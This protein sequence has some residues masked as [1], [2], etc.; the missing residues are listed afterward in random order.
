MNEIQQAAQ[1]AQTMSNWSSQALFL[2]SLMLIL[3]CGFRALKYCMA[4]M[5]KKDAVI[6]EITT[7]ANLTNDRLIACL[8]KNSICIDNSAASSESNSQMLEKVAV[9][10]RVCR[11][12]RM[13]H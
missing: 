12:S 8:E 3:F 2:A 7:K 13:V 9:E 5:E 1:A 11:E 6:L 4:Q 10:L